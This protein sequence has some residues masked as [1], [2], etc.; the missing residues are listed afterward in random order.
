MTIHALPSASAWAD[1]KRI[2]P[3]NVDAEQEILGALLTFP[4]T[5]GAVR[6]VLL[7]E[8]FSEALHGA[9]YQAALSAGE[10]CQLP[11]LAVI[12]QHVGERDWSKDLGG[13]TLNAY[14]GR[15]IS[16]TPPAHMAL[17]AAKLVRDLWALRQAGA[18]A[19]SI[20]CDP[21]GYDPA[22]KLSEWFA[23]TDE[24]RASL[25]ERERTSATA[26]QAA[27]S[28]LARIET[29][30]QG[31]ALPLP[32]TGLP[33]LDDAIGGGLQRAT[34][35]VAAGRPGMGKSLVGIEICDAVA[36][37]GFASVY[38]SLEMS[39]LQV[40]ARQISS[41][42][43]RLGLRVPFADLMRGRVS[44]EEAARV[45]EVRAE[46]RAVP[47]QIEEAGG[48]S[49]ADV[50]S[51]TERRVNAFVRKGFKPGLAVIDHAHQLRPTRRDRNQEGDI[52]EASAGALALAKHLQMPVLLL[53]Q[54]NRG[55][56]GREDKRPGPADL[57]GSGALEEDADTLIFPYRPAFYVER[58]A[59]Y[60]SGNPERVAEHAAVANRLEL[61]IDKNRAGPPNIVVSAWVDPA[62]N[63]MRPDH[64]VSYAEVRG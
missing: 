55:P 5:L 26:E 57:R 40:S 3:A 22:T 14:V 10:T 17:A 16:H 27:G 56:E 11:S 58:S 19:E 31:K 15:L 38:N 12:R 33:K 20:Y 1:L 23:Q 36:S 51:T 41:R 29:V 52:R 37:Q 45:A 46:L 30:L 44:A 9:L 32:Q 50:A 42:L 6:S 28:V 49:I 48:V 25:I 54:L 59:E 18:L 21:S 34:L 47:F 8:H 63:A 43:E 13:V 24:L 2:V 64:P 39:A 7:P 53:A 62:L 35:T 4:E 61:I 60:R